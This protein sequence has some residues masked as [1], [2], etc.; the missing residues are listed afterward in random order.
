[1][2][3]NKASEFDR[4]K[5][6]FAQL[7]KALSHPARIAILEILASKEECMC[8]NI[9]TILPLAQSTVS[10]H[11]KTLKEAGLIKGKITGPSI[12]YDVDPEV[13]RECCGLFE[14]FSEK[15]FATA[16]VRE[17]E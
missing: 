5:V 12:C 1:M 16:K 13:L 7:T 9:S 4:E 17:D 3:L 6:R 10:Q 11:L 2:A 8:G 14:Q 15:M